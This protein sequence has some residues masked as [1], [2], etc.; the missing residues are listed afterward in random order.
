MPNQRPVAAREPR[1]Q[2]DRWLWHWCSAKETLVGFLILIALALAMSYVLPQIP[3]QVR[4]DPISY[5]ERLAAIQVTFRDWTPMLESIGGFY[6]HDTFW[7]RTLLAVLAFVILVSTGKQIGVLFQPLQVEQPDTFYDTPDATV[8]TTASP[9]AQVTEVV[10]QIMAT[11]FGRIQQETD[12]ERVYL[13]GSHNAW[14]SASTAVICLGLLFVVGGLAINGRWGWLQSDVQL[15]PDKPVFIGLDGSHKVEFVNA[16]AATTEVILQ[17]GG[18]ENVSMGSGGLARRRGYR[19]QLL[20]KGGPLVRI[21]ARGG[22]GEMLTLYDY[23]VRPEPVHSLWFTFSS[24]TPKEEADR[25]FIVSEERIVGRLKWLDKSVG[26]SEEKPH[27]HLWVFR[28][29]GRT[30][31]GEQEISTRENTITATVGNITFAFN[32]SRFVVVEVAYQPGLWVLRIGGVLVIIGLLGSL[33]PRQQMWSAVLAQ[34]DSVTVKI[35]ERSGG[36]S[37]GYRRQRDQVLTRLRD[38]IGEA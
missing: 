15:L 30:L 3:A 36:L 24:A 5:Q 10:R 23:D 22:S 35:R 27:F 38:Q 29:D 34:A 37:Y 1:W 17:V 20:D 16:Q 31:V 13:Y 14:V 33:L 2:I 8:V 7:F 26:T 21:T 25:L 32:V 11:L 12:G 9:H 28:E 18:R 6:I 19:Y 4:V